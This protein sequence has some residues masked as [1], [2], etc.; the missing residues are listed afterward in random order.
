MGIKEELEQ[1]Q[2]AI[3]THVQALETCR[4]SL[5]KQANLHF[6]PKLSDGSV[7]LQ[8]INIESGK[9]EA[10]DMAGIPAAFFYE[11]YR[12]FIPDIFDR[13][14]EMARNSSAELALSFQKRIDEE[15]AALKQT[16]KELAPFLPKKTAR[17]EDE[18]PGVL[19]EE[20]TAHRTRGRPRKNTPVRMR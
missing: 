19:Q 8:M 10:A 18:E 16:Q 12:E 20:V 9:A 5:K 6:V 14:I 13:A 17:I 3:Q 7:S 15:M 11:A 2:A 4:E 1:Q